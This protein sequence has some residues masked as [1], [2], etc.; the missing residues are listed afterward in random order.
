MFHPQFHNSSRTI[1]KKAY[2]LSVLCAIEVC[3]IYY[4]PDGQ[5]KTWPKEKEKVK[6]IALRYKEARKR[7]KSLNL[8][9]FLEK[10][11]DKDKDKVTTNLKKKNVKYPHWY[12]KFDHYSPQQL[13]QLIQSLERTL[14]KLQERLRV[15][16]AKKQ[17]NNT[18][19][20]HPNQHLNPENFSLY[21]YNHDDAILSQ[22]PFNASHANL[23][24]NYQNHLMKQELYDFGQNM[25]MDNITNTNFHHPCYSNTQGYAPLLSQ[26]ELNGFD[27]NMV[28][29]SNI[30]NNNGL[31]NTVPHE[32]YPNEL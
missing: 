12:P 7:K 2:E 1:F 30:T 24:S 3:V 21:M 19:L 10:E 17:R 5:L 28:L 25:C 16:E 23:L 27:Q 31:S 32:F 6:D 11:K 14:S 29:M 18:N 9:E 26:K 15:V 20:V 4:G 22:P 8:H 13:S